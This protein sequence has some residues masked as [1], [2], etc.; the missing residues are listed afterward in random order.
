MHIMSLWLRITK[1]TVTFRA[2]TALAL[3]LLSVALP[4]SAK[5]FIV[6]I[7]TD[8]EVK[9]YQDAVQG[10][11]SSCKCSV[12]EVRLTEEGGTKTIL[13]TDP[14]IILAVG[15]AAFRKVRA[16]RDLPIVHL[17]VIPSETVALSDNI[18]GV[19]MDLAPDV[20]LD[21]M[22][23]L[24]PR[25]RKIGLL[26]DPRQTGQFVRDAL[27]AANSRGI[28]LVVKTVRSSREVSEL[29]D[30]LR[31][32]VDLFWMLPDPLI[33]NPETANSILLYS[34][35]NN[36]PVITFSSKY[37]DMGAVAALQAGPFEMGAQ[38]GELARA[39]SEGKK[40]A[41]RAYANKY[42]LFV[43]KKVAAKMGVRLDPEFIMKAE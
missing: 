42:R 31:D 5:A 9:P 28:E 15:T 23:G 2:L 26:H 19:S 38:A 10:F 1:R 13:D 25:A 35:Q 14:D 34:F 29:L 32:T 43:N 8:T 20:Y 39:L 18:S 3:L 24:F 40:A 33:A 27:E 4:S 17:M 37:V 11:K 7:V 12:R 16:I 6:T 21:A 36:V 30:A 22:T 41:P